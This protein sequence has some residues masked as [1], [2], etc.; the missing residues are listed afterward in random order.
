MADTSVIWERAPQEYLWRA[1]S[2]EYGLEIHNPLIYTFYWF[3]FKN[4]GETSVS[5][6]SATSRLRA[7]RAIADELDELEKEVQHE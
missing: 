6:G 4:D 2:G 5:S 1:S 3:I 7:E